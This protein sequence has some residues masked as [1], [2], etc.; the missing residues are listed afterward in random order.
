MPS[1]CC[2]LQALCWRACQVAAWLLLQAAFK[3]ITFGSGSSLAQLVQKFGKTGQDKLSVASNDD[4]SLLLALVIPCG[5][6]QQR[7]GGPILGCSQ[8]S[9]NLGPSHLAQKC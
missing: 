3:H 6:G 9:Q 8:A 1:A 4:L 5:A 7:P 2:Q